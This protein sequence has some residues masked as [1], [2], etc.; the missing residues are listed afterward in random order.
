MEFVALK[1]EDLY[2][3]DLKKLGRV[4]IKELSDSLASITHRPS[5]GG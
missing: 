5:V 4:K 2:F 3:K 1:K